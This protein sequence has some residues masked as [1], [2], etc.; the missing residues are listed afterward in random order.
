MRAARPR[1][2]PP[3]PCAAARPRASRGAARSAGWSSLMRHSSRNNSSAW[4]RV[5]TKTR[6][7]PGGLLSGRVRAPARRRCRSGRPRAGGAS[8][9][10]ICTSGAG[11][12][13]P[14]ISNAARCPPGIGEQRRRPRRSPRG[15]RRRSPAQ[16]RQPRE[17]SARADAALGAASAWSSSTITVA[18][19][20]NIAGALRKESSSA[21]DSGVVSRMSGGAPLAQPALRRVAGP[22][23]ARTARPIS[24]I[25]VRRLRAMSAV[26]ALSGET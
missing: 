12:G 8:G 7:V 26:S 5:L 13:A 11:A 6:V 14:S 10:R 9:S 1:P 22:V 24:S 16:A 23:S 18:R 25:G 19:P 15:R 20:P 21:S 3:R 4:A 2:S 17:A